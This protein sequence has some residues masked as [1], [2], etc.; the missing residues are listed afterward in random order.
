MRLR[1]SSGWGF[2]ATQREGTFRQIRISNAQSIYVV[3]GLPRSFVKQTYL[4]FLALS[5][6]SPV[7]A[8]AIQSD[9]TVC[10]LEIEETAGVARRN[11]PVVL[12]IASLPLST[13]SAEC[14][15]SVLDGRHVLVSQIDRYADDTGRQQIELSFQIDLAPHEKRE[16]VLVVEAIPRQTDT[17][18]DL[19][20]SKAGNQTTI[21][22]SAF[23]WQ[24][25]RAEDAEFRF[26]SPEGA[27]DNCNLRIWTWAG[28]GH[29]APL[30]D[31]HYRHRRLLNQVCFMR[32]RGFWASADHRTHL[33]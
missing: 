5:L 10:T 29:V 9:N 33:I 31:E 26:K 22:N 28:R 23:E 6:S 21:S 32:D 25:S 11:W 12:P 18:S 20:V 14:V 15:I 1:L 8:V 16:L 3:A 19:S 4:V 17:R 27:G 2:E 7:A 30:H 13:A 24:L